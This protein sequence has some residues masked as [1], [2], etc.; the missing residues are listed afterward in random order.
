MYAESLASICVHGSLSTCVRNRDHVY[1]R[2][3][4][5]FTLDGGGG[6]D[7]YI[8]ISRP[9]GQPDAAVVVIERRDRLI[10]DRLVIEWP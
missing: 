4:D 5:G 6:V 8:S 1:Q 10:H 7:T 3:S 9:D 2:A